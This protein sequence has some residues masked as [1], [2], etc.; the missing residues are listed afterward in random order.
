MLN[1]FAML[2]AKRSTKSTD[3]SKL[4]EL[5]GSV[6]PD[7]SAD[8]TCRRNADHNT[9]ILPRATLSVIKSEATVVAATHYDKPHLSATE[10]ENSQ[11]TA[12]IRCRQNNV[13]D[14]SFKDASTNNHPVDSR[15]LKRM[16]MSFPPACTIVD[17]MKRKTSSDY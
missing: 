9:Y 10:R 8:C 1:A 6:K 11:D 12:L 15:W 17:Q 3:P 13:H 16:P 5:P 7:A 4:H 14:R 2:A